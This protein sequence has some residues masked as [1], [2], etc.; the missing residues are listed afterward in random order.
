MA[1]AAAKAHA[2]ETYPQEACG[3]LKNGTY[4]RCTNTA[5]EKDTF[6][7]AAEEW[8]NLQPVE[9]LIHSHPDG[10]GFPSMQDMKSQIDMDI[11][12]GLIVV[13]KGGPNGEIMAADPWFWGDTLPIAPLTMRDF[14]HGPS[15]T[16]N[17]GD[18]YAL[19]RDVYRSDPAEIQAAIDRATGRIHAP[20]PPRHGAPVQRTLETWPLAAPVVLDEIP[21]DDS[22]WT[23]GSNLYLDH[24]NAVGFDAIVKDPKMV[25]AGDIF[26]TR[27]IS[28]VPNHGMVYLGN[29]LI[30]HHK[31]GRPAN[32]EPCHRW[33]P[34]LTHVLRYR[35]VS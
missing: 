8:H 35:G 20:A 28:K 6:V 5:T 26:L 24:F 22:W 31:P 33:F 16:D 17:K 18:C 14:R 15:G 21:R 27:L 2:V 34:N 23:K 7:I 1:R 32:I 19:I 4:V 25:R 3:V 13:G 9:A 12:W 29:N 11:P 10:P 30:M